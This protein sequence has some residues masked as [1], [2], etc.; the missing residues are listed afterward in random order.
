MNC[1]QNCI[2]NT[3]HDSANISNFGFEIEIRISGISF[4]IKIELQKFVYHPFEFRF[5]T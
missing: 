5:E 4:D 1:E 3:K 2:E